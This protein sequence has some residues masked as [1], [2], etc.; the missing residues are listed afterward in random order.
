VLEDINKTSRRNV[1]SLECY[2][3]ELGYN[4]IKETEYF[5]SLQKSV[6][7]SEEYN[8]MVNSDELI[9]ATLSLTL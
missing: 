6:V 7:L 2:R 3:V 4:V 8:V 5:I 1:L 9:R